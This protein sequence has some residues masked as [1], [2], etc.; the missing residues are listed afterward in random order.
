MKLKLTQR[1]VTEKE[2][3]IDLPVYFY[4]QGETLDDEWI[5]WDGKN[6]I[7]V[8]SDYN[9]MTV[10]KS[11]SKFYVEEYWTSRICSKEEFDETM[12]RALKYFKK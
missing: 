3:D 2:T 7:T 12:E 9:G 8:K 1:A 5:M 11:R 4:F 6:K 10:D